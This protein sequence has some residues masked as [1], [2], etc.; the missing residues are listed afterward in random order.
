MHR[1]LKTAIRARLNDNSWLDLLPLVLL[2]LRSAWREGPEATPAELLYGSSLRL[3]GQFVPGSELSSPSQPMSSFVTSFQAKMKA[4]R[5]APSAH[6]A[7]P[8]PHLPSSLRTATSV[9]VRHDGA[10]RPLQ[11]PYDRPFPVLEARDKTFIIMKNRLPYT[12]SVDRLKPF[13]SPTLPAS[14]MVP[15]RRPPGPLPLPLP[16]DGPQS[17]LLY[18]SPSPRDS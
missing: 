5:L 8:V 1:H 2:G 6:H 12:V 18:T 13:Y 3:P 9:L 10:R 16:L 7:S 14:S 4:Q 11:P 15:V 17:C